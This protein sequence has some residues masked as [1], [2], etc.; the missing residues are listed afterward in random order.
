MSSVKAVCLVTVIG[1]AV[2]AP[3]ALAGPP[4]AVA[5]PGPEVANG[6]Y[7]PPAC[8]GLFAD[9]AC[10]GGFAVNWI[11]QFYNDAITSGCGTNP[12]QYCPDNPVTRAQMAVFVERAMRGNAN[13]PPH[14]Q[15][16][17]AVKNP[18]GTPN[19]TAS[20]TALVN[21]V[22]AIPTSGND[23]PSSTNPWL[24]KVGPGIYDLGSGSLTLPTYTA[25]E[26]AGR[27]VTVIT[28]AGYADNAHG[29]VIVNAF[30][31]L[32]RLT[33]ANTGGDAYE[34]AVYLPGGAGGVRLEHVSLT[35]SNP[36]NASGAAYGLEADMST[37]FSLLDCE[38]TANGAYT[39]AGVWRSFL[40]N[41]V[42][43]DGSQMTVS[44]ANPA[45]ADY[46]IY[47]NGGSMMITNARL[48]VVDGA[49][50]YGVYAYDG[51]TLDLRNTEI[52]TYGGGAAA[53][54]GGSESAVLVGD[55]LQS[56]GGGYGISTNGGGSAAE[57][58][59]ST[60]TGAAGWLQNGAGHTVT[61]GAS[62]LVGATVNAGTVNCFGNY[63][64]SAFLASTCP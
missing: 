2:V 25:L 54:A 39:N 22:A 53:Y 5:S 28:A 48:S 31:R 42:W 29:T 45:G 43:I 58:T 21:A 1:C 4:V 37:S 14:T 17:W 57:I 49:L 6:P 13:W 16:V 60:I 10:P 9:V 32:S 52:Y 26:G 18:D 59:A 19:P 12:L 24:L 50:Q 3:V 63:T 44:G 46:C 62:K 64:G 51:Y 56:T 20:G 34:I 40:G 35:A 23:V 7:T 30:G 55:L 36:S 47:V 15:L 61:V 33:V 41:D 38:I 8:T 11:E 27:E